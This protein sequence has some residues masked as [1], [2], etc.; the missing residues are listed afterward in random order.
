MRRLEEKDDLL[1]ETAQV[2]LMAS[3][4]EAFEREESKEGLKGLLL[5]VGL[6]AYRAPREGELVDTCQALQAK[7][8]IAA[9]KGM[10]KELGG[11]A[12]EVES[13]VS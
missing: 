12:N 3:L 1:P 10:D 6:L 4:L 9:K 13:V 7:E 8:N 5:A 11:L 2:E